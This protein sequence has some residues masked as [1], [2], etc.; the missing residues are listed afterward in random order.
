MARHLDP[1]PSYT[2]TLPDTEIDSNDGQ[3]TEIDSNSQCECIS[4]S[5]DEG[6]ASNTN[7][8][9]VWKQRSARFREMSAYIKT[10]GCICVNLSSVDAIEDFAK[11]VQHA[12][13]EI[14]KILAAGYVAAFKIGITYVPVARM[15]NPQHGY[16]VALYHRMVILSI[17][18]DANFIAELEIQVI[19][20]YR[21]HDRRGQ[22]I[23][24]DGHCL[25]A[26]RNPGG[27]IILPWCCTAFFVCG[28]EAQ[29]SPT[30]ELIQ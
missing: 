22:C 19:K 8:E 12:T 20:A 27:G 17:H 15:T 25:C 11:Q 6:S 21:R 29:P 13:S 1:H 24:I 9:E 18:D 26:N 2:P 4:I 28:S 10:L 3:D 16:L 5:S 23:R 14:D 7:T 30:F